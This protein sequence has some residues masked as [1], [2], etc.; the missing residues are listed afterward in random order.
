[1]PTHRTPLRRVAASCALSVMALACHAQPVVG[2]E[3]LTTRQGRMLYV[4]DNDV[5]GSGRSVCNAP[6]SNVFPP[7]V[8]EE[9]AQAAAPL[10]IVRR[11]DG[12]RQWS[13]K[14]RPLYVFYADDK[15]GD[16]NGDGMNR[17][18]WHVARP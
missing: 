3:T 15:P 10:G 4:F 17:G 1:M 6:C 7:Y 11:D 18:I 8:V 9:G 14:G 2:S 13:Y 12:S 5:T 16:R